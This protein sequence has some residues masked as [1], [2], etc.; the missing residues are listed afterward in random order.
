[1]SKGLNGLITAAVI[2]VSFG[3][4]RYLFGAVQTHEQVKQVNARAEDA[5]S[6]PVVSH[7]VF[8]KNF[9]ANCDDGT[10]DGDDFDQTA[11]CNCTF[12]A[13]EDRYGLNYMAQSALNDTEEE[14]IAKFA[15]EMSDCLEQQG[16]FINESEIKESAI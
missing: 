14:M 10:L 4:T 16:H 8:H 15:P 2:V 9:M 7:G 6:E 3:A 5:Q 11:Y 1:M 13:M 12:D